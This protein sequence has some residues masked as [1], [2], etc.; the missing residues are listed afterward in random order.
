MSFDIE[1]QNLGSNPPLETITNVPIHLN[2][3]A[4]QSVYINVVEEGDIDGEYD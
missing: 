4:D 2:H 1:I 3:Q